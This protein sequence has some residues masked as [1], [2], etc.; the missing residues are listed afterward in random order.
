MTT[1]IFS[2]IAQTHYAQL[3]FSRQPESKAAITMTIKTAETD[4]LLMYRV[5]RETHRD[6]EGILVVAAVAPCEP[7]R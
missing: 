6:I 7:A 5:A 2:A 3:I 1:R 4:W